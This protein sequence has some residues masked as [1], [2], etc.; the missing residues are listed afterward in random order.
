MRELEALP[1]EEATRIWESMTPM[2]QVRLANAMT[3]EEIDAMPAETTALMRNMKADTLERA[4]GELESAR[5]TDGRFMYIG[6]GET[7]ELT[8]EYC[9]R[10]LTK[11]S[12]SFELETEESLGFYAYHTL[13]LWVE[14]YTLLL[15]EYKKK[16]EG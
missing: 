1:K 6:D 14:A 8:E 9:Q 3:T 2:E 7:F 5:T 10:R 12:K 16:E 15:D 13:R 4:L 11:L